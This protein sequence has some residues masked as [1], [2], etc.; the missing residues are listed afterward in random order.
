MAALA[1]SS[2]EEVLAEWSGLGYYARAR[3]LHRAARAVVAAGGEVPRSVEG[4]RAL[5]GVGPYTAAA[6]AS[7]AFG[8]PVPLV[9]GN[10]ARVLARLL[11][12]PGD[13][14]KG[15]ARATIEG[16]AA[17]L[18][19]PRSPGDH[20]QALMELGA[21]VCLPRAPR[22]A[23]CPFAE[24]CRARAEG[25]PERYPAPRA[26][27]PAIRLELEA[28]VARRGGRIVLVE[29]THLV[30]GH[31]VVP[32]AP[33]AGGEAGEALRAA[34]P[35]LA[36]RRIRALRPAGRVRHSVLERRYD[37]EVFLVSEGSATRGASPALLRPA[38]LARAP[39]GGLTRK[40]LALIGAPASAQAS[41]AP[42]ARSRRGRPRPKPTGG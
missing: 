20:N 15:A 13:V 25:A 3:N 1:A 33:A 37:V 26:R 7:I 42:P 18:L 11:A 31:L 14:R 19:D 39:L 5:P 35:A 8:A 4:L 17:A 16:T 6:I 29:D 27:R 36:G 12:V 23:S 10:V 28:G 2:E 32:V 38:D 21:L 40:V 9:D 30:R 24:A 41:A 34:W 22:C